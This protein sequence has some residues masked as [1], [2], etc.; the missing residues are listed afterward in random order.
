[1]PKVFNPTEFAFV[2]HNVNGHLYQIPPGESVEVREQDVEDLLHLLGF[3]IV[4]S[5]DASDTGEKMVLKK[6][7]AEE[8]EKVSVAAEVEKNKKPQYV[9]DMKM[10]VENPATGLKEEIPCQFTA[11]TRR[12][13]VAHKKADHD[14]GDYKT[15]RATSRDVNKDED[16][17]PRRRPGRPRKE[18]AE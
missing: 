1:M 9:C 2:N 14:G 6:G 7:G 11:I 17:A 13:V 10:I 5:S 18:S 4:M 12:S 3:L 15:R 16:E 8:M